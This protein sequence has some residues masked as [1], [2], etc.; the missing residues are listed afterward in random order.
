MARNKK[1][2]LLLI[3]FILSLPFW[4]GMNILAREIENFYYWQEIANKPEIFTA[5]ASQ[6]FASK[7][8]RELKEDKQRLENL[9]HLKVNA[10]AAISVKVDNKGREKVLFEKNPDERLPIASITKLMTALVVY[11]FKETYNLSQLI[12][13]SKEAVNQEGDSKWGDLKVGEKLSVKNLLH[14][15]LI[16]SSN[17]AAFALTEP[18]G[19]KGFVDLMN[20]ESRKI[21]LNN[22]RFFNPTGLEPDEPDGLINYSTVRDLVRLA[23]YILKN[24]PQIFK[25]SLN[26][27][28]VIL[29]PNGALHHF[30]PENT[31]KLLGK[32][33]G[34]I[35]GKTGWSPKASGCLLLILKDPKGSGYFIN[36]VLGSKDRFGDMEKII[37]GKELRK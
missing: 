33:P 30:I 9:R 20:I 32:V 1:L 22:T 23:Q 14:M 7:K 29:K 25:I 36:V 35:G 3:S 24:Y 19:E 26:Q 11:D 31:N 17:D 4:W 2:A 8:L 27:S 15:A 37:K 13:I 12:T 6:Q 21:G 10:K 16:E 18:I 34:I 28:Y 5:Q